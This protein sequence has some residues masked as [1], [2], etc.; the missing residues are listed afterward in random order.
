MECFLMKVVVPA[1]RLDLCDFLLET[2][3]G[4]MSYDRSI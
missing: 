4:C 1:T 2:E 3:G